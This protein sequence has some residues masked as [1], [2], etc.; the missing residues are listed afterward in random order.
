MILQLQAQT[1]C[2]PAIKFRPYSI[3][4]D[5]SLI[6]THFLYVAFTTL[7]L[8]LKLVI[9]T[10]KNTSKEKMLKILQNLLIKRQVLSLCNT[11]FASSMV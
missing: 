3:W 6:V 5:V 2:F 4:D 10:L 9:N 11:R 7:M 8:G 1:N